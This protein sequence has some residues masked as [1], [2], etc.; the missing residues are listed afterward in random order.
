M[1]SRICAGEHDSLGYGLYVSKPSKNA[2][3]ATGIDLIFNSNTAH[4]AGTI[5]QIIDI[6][7]ASSGTFDGTGTIS[8]LAY[9][10]FIHITE[11]T[12][13]GVKGMG[14]WWGRSVGGG[15]GGSCILTD[16]MIKH[17]L[18]ETLIQDMK[19]GQRIT[20]YDLENN[21][22]IETYI[23]G[24]S[25]HLADFYYKVN[26][27]KITAGHPIWTEEGWAC[28]D[29]QAYYDECQEYSHIPILTPKKLEVGYTLSNGK[30]KEIERVDE[31]VQ[32]WNI[33]VAGTHN[34]FADG[35]LVHNGGGGGG[36][37]GSGRSQI[38]WSNWRATVTSSQIKITPW[39]SSGANQ[40]FNYTSGIHNKATGL[41]W[42]GQSFTSGKTFRCF[43]YRIP[44]T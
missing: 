6:T 29:P 25:E 30:I 12:S 38:K 27:L 26:N 36:G 24:K 41:S 2:Q 15:S 31:V 11:Y 23:T 17:P 14:S 9:I 19:E 20:G 3:T 22:E 37:G 7:C 43:V 44:A 33:E 39:M 16:A 28:I 32:V 35:I 18:G 10:P 34:Y 42:P 8:G 21:K 4:G 40:N 5:H 13:S 1:A